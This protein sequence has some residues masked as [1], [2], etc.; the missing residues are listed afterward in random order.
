MI[1]RQLV[2]QFHPDKHAHLGPVAAKEAEERFREVQS[3]YELLR[4]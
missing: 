3:A 2:K 1:H 4:A